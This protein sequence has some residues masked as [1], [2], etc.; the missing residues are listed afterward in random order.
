MTLTYQRLHGGHRLPWSHSLG[1]G[2]ENTHRH[3]GRRAEGSLGQTLAL[4]APT[5]V[6]IALPLWEVRELHQP[7]GPLRREMTGRGN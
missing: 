7:A 2:R 3:L 6:P 5:S 4:A 1:A